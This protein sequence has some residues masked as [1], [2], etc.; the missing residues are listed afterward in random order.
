LTLEKIERSYFRLFLKKGSTNRLLAIANKFVIKF[1][2]MLVQL[3]LRRSF[4]VNSKLV[5]RPSPKA[6]GCVEITP[7][8]YD[9]K[10]AL[11]L[12]ADLE[13]CWAWRFTE[14]QHARGMLDRKHL[15]H[16]LKALDKYSIPITWA[17]V[18]HL[19]LKECVRNENGIA[20]PD[21]PRPEGCYD[22]WYKDDPCNNVDN[23][24]DWYG[25]DLISEIMNTEVHHEIGV[26]S[27]SHVDF[28]DKRCTRNVALH[29]LKESIRLMKEFNIEPR[30]LVYPF[31]REG[32]WSLLPEV[33][34]TSFRGGSGIYII[35]YPK[36]KLHELWDIHQSSYLKPTP[37]DNWPQIGKFCIDKAI[38]SK[39]VYHLW[40]HPSE[41]DSEMTRKNLI[42]ILEYASKKRAEGE[43]WIATMGEIASYCEAREKTNINVECKEEEVRITLHTTVNHEKFGFPEITLKVNLKK[44]I[45]KAVNVD[46]KTIETDATRFHRNSG[47]TSNFLMVTVPLRVKEV[48][49]VKE[50]KNRG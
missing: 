5:T 50:L 13:L 40:F 34:I 45:P 19:F 41:I 42:P 36:S 47:S 12:T 20:H 11:C 39:S 8:K 6:F 49:I 17:V 29:E 26:H 37:L 15:P 21:M 23:N 16:L 7:F 27:F 44:S 32:H 30:S 28:S 1:F 18:G 35:S 25:P 4:F 48:T 24:P 22:T 2:E 31:C 46:G 9:A 10:A 33:Y 43:L 38:K 3:K 14:S